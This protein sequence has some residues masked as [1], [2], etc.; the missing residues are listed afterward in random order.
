MSDYKPKKSE[1]GWIPPEERDYTVSKTH[2]EILETSKVFGAEAFVLKDSGAGKV[3]LLHKYL[4][5][6]CGGVFPVNHQTIG[7][8]FVAGTMVLGEVTKSIEHVRIGDRV[9]TAQGRLTKVVSRREILT[10]KPMVTIKP[11]GGLPMTCTAD[12]RFLVYRMKR[13][14]GKRV[15]ENY[16]R[17][18]LLAESKGFSKSAVIECY[19]S[20]KPEWV[21]AEDLKDTDYL[22]TPS[23]FA[24]VAAPKDRPLSMWALGYFLG[25]GYASKESQGMTMELA[26]ACPDLAGR[27]MNDITASGFEPKLKPYREGAKAWRIRVHSRDLCR[28][29]RA[30]F[31]DDA[32][33][34]Q[35]P[36][37]A[38]GEDEFLTGLHAADGHVSKSYHAID[39][40][41]QSIVHGV[42]AT[43]TQRGHEP[44]VSEVTRSGG[45]Y[46]N[47]KPLYRVQWNPK[48][49]QK[50]YI[51]RDE[52]FVCRP[53][54]S[55]ELTEGPATVYDIGVADAHH[56]FIA[57]GV[58]VHNCVS[59]GWAKAIEILIAV[60]I[61]SH[62]KPEEWP[63]V[64][65]ATEW[66]Y[67]TGRVLVGGGR[68]GNGDGSLGSW[69]AKAVKEHGVL[70]RRRYENADLTTYD[71]KR[72]KAYGYRGLPVQLEP[73]ADEHP[74]QTTALITT[75]EE[76]RDA[77]A[78]GY[79]V[80]V[81]SNQG[82]SNRR[83]E[84]GFARPSG[85]WAHCMTLISSDDTGDRPGLL[86]MN[87]WGESWIS[88]TRRH[89]QPEGSFWIDAETC[90]RMLRGKDS[91][92]VSNF[93]GFP[94]QQ[95]DYVF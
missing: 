14:G 63:G 91:Y 34:K 49:K 16:Y 53:I 48:G 75:Y 36:A 23:K 50:A 29:L 41:S 1:L 32:G 22:L 47:A 93:K 70:F 65:V 13:V 86:C 78:N 40:T 33:V 57:N 28:W 43:L 17:R 82:F 44:I 58:A 51:W 3:V 71:G 55:K 89:D 46:P 56:S 7:D 11:L 81:C 87:S 8:C 60:Q 24:T 74:V 37:W 15:T 27:I 61:A 67:G 4:E 84:Q 72:A 35:F 20:R 79:P 39:S 12:H 30:Y 54:Q 62:N 66:L 94:R 9:Y 5:Q 45:E 25:D 2:A 42:M 88:G 92:A 80:P 31:Y 64:L 6:F 59:H 76:A 85:S 69:Q 90:D 95:L 21:C 73:I 77:I 18:A 38:I 83:D 68:L 10:H 19:E 26:V 52:H